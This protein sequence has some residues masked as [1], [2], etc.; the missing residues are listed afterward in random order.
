MNPRLTLGLLAVLIALGG[1]VYLGGPSGGQANQPT[2]KDQTSNQQ[3]EVFKFEDRDT[4]R[5]AVRKG[6]QQTVVEK[7][8]DGNWTLPSTGE[9]AD[10]IRLS[11]ITLRLAGLRATR[12]FDEPA[13]PADYGLDN[14]QTMVAIDQSD[15]AQYSLYFG[16]KAPAEAGTYARRGDETVVFVV[17]NALVQDLE[18]LITEPPRQPPTPTPAPTATPTPEAEPTATPTP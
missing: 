3:L 9:P 8:A 7:D 5:L 11:G 10:K 16:A 6:D 15:G 4:Q 18:R 13:N 1:Y 12:R 14:P 17:S 2:A